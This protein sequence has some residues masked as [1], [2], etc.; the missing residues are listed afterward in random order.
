MAR[1]TP[2]FAGLHPSCDASSHAMRGNVA[3]DTQPE[4]EFDRLSAFLNHLAAGYSLQK[5]LP[6][7]ARPSRCC[8]L[9]GEARRLL[10]WGLLARTRLGHSKIEAIPPGQCELLDLQDRDQHRE[11]PQT[12][13]AAPQRR[14]ACH[15][16]LGR[17]HLA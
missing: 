8:F 14:V 4:R 10:R 11:R 16:D 5:A 15:A 13:F 17:G 3:Q 6:R 1:S 2:S 7:A 12:G 9:S